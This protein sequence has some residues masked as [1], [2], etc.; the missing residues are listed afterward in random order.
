MPQKHLQA[1]TS[2]ASNASTAIG[3]IENAGFIETKA[4][5]SVEAPETAYGFSLNPKP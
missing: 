1:W 3:Y 4:A 5:S 2:L